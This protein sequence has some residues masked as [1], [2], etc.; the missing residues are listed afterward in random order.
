M[1]NT[2]QAIPLS[3]GISAA[4]N[5]YLTKEITEE[6]ILGVVKQINPLKAPGLDELQAIFYKKKQG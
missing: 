4:D 6:E 5:E 1:I 2:L 3:R